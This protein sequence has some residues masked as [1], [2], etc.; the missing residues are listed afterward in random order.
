LK[1]FDEN[2]LFL[3]QLFPIHTP[4]FTPFSSFHKDQFFV[5]A[6]EKRERIRVFFS[7]EVFIFIQ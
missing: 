6:A 4:Y 2:R 7:A 3:Y 5:F 1:L